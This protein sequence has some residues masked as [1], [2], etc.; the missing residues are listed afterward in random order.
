MVTLPE[1]RRRGCASAVLASL[2]DWFKAHE[3]A[4]I[5]LHATA[6]S[7]L[8][9]RA[10]GFDTPFGHALSRYGYDDPRRRM[11]GVPHD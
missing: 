3:V 10:A 6:P 4:T 9:Y 5:E 11:A 2:L 8:M 1:F 7:E